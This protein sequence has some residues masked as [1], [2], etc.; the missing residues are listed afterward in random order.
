MLY[1]IIQGF[2]EPELQFSGRP[3]V[4]GVW[5]GSGGGRSLLL[6]GHVDTVPHEPL[7]EWVN[8]P[9]SGAIVNDKIFGRGASDM[10]AG[11]A[12]M[13]MAVRVARG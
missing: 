6:N 4:V 3:N 1:E 2:T 5:K 10:K 8:G 12:A 7:S 11:L 13:T 9:L